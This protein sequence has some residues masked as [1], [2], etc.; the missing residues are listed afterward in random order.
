MPKFR[1]GSVRMKQFGTDTV[2]DEA[3]FTIDLTILRASY[4]FSSFGNDFDWFLTAGYQSLALPR[5]VYLR[6]SRDTGGDS[7]YSAYHQLPVFQDRLWSASYSMGTIGAGYARRQSG[8]HDGLTLDA[9]LL[10]HL[11]SYALAPL[12]GPSQYSGFAAGAE[13]GGTI[14]YS[15]NLA[16]NCYVGLEDHISLTAYSGQLPDSL[17]RDAEAM[18]PGY[19]DDSDKLSLAFGSVDILN[20][21]YA[22][23]RIDF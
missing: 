20:N 7:D 15:W 13:L 21:F 12:G 16:K 2:I 1:N 3:D 6:H 18:I 22:F 10:I 23:L 9:S 5:G 8:G 4:L 17:E 19:N 14:G 11:G